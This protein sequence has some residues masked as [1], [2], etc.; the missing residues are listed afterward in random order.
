M[1]VLQVLLVFA[2]VQVNGRILP[3]TSHLTDAEI[4]DNDNRDLHRRVLPRDHLSKCSPP[5]YGTPYYRRDGQ[6]TGHNDTFWKRMKLPPSQEQ[7][8]RFMLEETGGAHAW[9]IVWD[10]RG[11]DM[12]T[13]DFETFRNRRKEFSF[14]THGLIG[15]TVLAI[16]S[17]KGVYIAHYWESISF[18]I[19]Q[20]WLEKYKT[21]E[22]AFDETVIQALNNGIKGQQKSLRS[23]KPEV[24]DEHIRAYLMRPFDSY[25]ETEDGYR[26][27]WNRMKDTVGDILPTLK[28]ESRWTEIIYHRVASSEDL[29]GPR[30]RCLFKFDPKHPTGNGDTTTK[31][32]RFWSEANFR[33]WHEDDWDSTAPT[34]EG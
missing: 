32:T 24:D 30:G 23:H 34:A 31:S 22:R 17:R 7:M 28:D 15:C 33:P 16:I 14:Q 26:D 1:R 8:G 11:S 29:N 19:E 6:E 18:S 20:E 12:N 2:T 13:A 25:D 27:K 4:K 21:Q 5:T 10:S 9:P 3:D